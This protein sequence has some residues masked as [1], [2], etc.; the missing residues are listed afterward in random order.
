VKCVPKTFKG[1]LPA[2]LPVASG[3]PEVEAVFD[4]RAEVEVEA[5]AEDPVHHHQVVEVAAVPD[6]EVEGAVK[7]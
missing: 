7:D 2:L 1:F 3:L 4:H 6:P 5:E